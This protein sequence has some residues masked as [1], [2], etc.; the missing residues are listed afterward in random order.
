MFN[1]TPIYIYLYKDF[2]QENTRKCVIIGKSNVESLTIQKSKR[3]RKVAH[4]EDVSH[5][6]EILLL[7]ALLTN[8]EDVLSERALIFLKAKINSYKQQDIARYI[9]NESLL[10]SLQQVILKL[11]KSCLKCCYCCNDV[12]VMYRIVRDLKQWTLDRIDN[13]LC[14]S[15]SNTVIACLGCNLKRRVIDKDKFEFTKK[16]VL[17]KIDNCNNAETSSLYIVE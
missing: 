9:Y 1:I 12:K 10:I 6:R 15:D 7:N 13:S 8:S 3:I 17:K 4:T 11:H 2:M 16:L 5:S 14:H